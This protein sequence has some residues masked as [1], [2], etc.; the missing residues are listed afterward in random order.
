MPYL[1][2]VLFHFGFSGVQIMLF[3]DLIYSLCFGT[4]NL[5]L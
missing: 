1:E 3:I 5:Y 2:F 4:V